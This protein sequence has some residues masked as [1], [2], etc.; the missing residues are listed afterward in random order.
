MKAKEK[1]F[2][3]YTTQLRE[4]TTLHSVQTICRMTAQDV[5]EKNQL[6]NS[7]LTNFEQQLKR[8]YKAYER[9][10]HQNVLIAKINYEQQLHIL[11]ANR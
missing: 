2:E 7:V 10:R 11:D 8:D 9:E 4:V 5:T 3:T 6:I 1:S